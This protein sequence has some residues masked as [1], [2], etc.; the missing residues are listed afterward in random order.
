[1][2]D[3]ADVIGVLH[4]ARR[5][6]LGDVIG[7]ERM[8]TAMSIDAGTNNASRVLGP[9]VGGILLAL[10]RHIGQRER[11]DLWREEHGDR[12]VAEHGDIGRRVGATDGAGRHRR[13]VF[14]DRVR[15]ETGVLQQFHALLE[16][17][18]HHVGHRELRRSI[19]LER[20]EHHD[21]TGNEQRDCEETD[22]SV[23][24][25]ARTPRLWLHLLRL[26]RGAR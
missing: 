19:T 26:H 18:T 9:T 1:M 15:A 16:C 25:A 8:G 2:D 11:L 3:G 5:E 17:H 20:V 23:E 22:E 13:V 7:A 4:S 21:A 10:A 12:L 6:Q 24:A 14:L